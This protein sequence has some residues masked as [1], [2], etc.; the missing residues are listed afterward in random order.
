MLYDS[1]EIH[2]ESLNLALKNID[3]KYMISLE[4]H[5]NI[6][7]GLPTSRKLELLTELKQLP[8]NKHKEIWKNKQEYTSGL[9][10]KI[11]EDKQL[12]NIIKEIKNKGIKVACCSNSIKSTLIKF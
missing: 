9:L 6:F 10:S 4:E 7:D 11:K 1:K 3:S 12:I 8:E 2:Y 5:L